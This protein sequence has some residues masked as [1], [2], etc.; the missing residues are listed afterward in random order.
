[1]GNDPPGR[2]R[3]RSFVRREGRMT[4]AQR[5]ALDGLW[6]NY[7][8][9]YSQALLSLADIFGRN[10]PV[11]IDIGSGAGTFTFQHARRHPENNYIAIEVHRP[12]VGRLLRDIHKSGLKNIRI[13]NHDAVE[14]LEHQIASNTIDEITIFFPDP[15]PKKRHHKR[16]LIQPPFLQTLKSALKSNGR[17]FIATDW[18]DY[19]AHIMALC[20]HDPELINLAGRG[21]PAPRPKWRLLTAY[22]N[23]GLKLK[24]EVK[25]FYYA[26][27]HGRPQMP[28]VPGE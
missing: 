15:W 27:S 25:D 4:P 20:D 6:Q 3:I 26:K 17:L 2:R 12:G 7:G 23:R 21:N 10:A 28:S 19:A 11:I 1:M 9:A 13:I 22:E 24:H 8:V 14:V 18:P 5:A 16:R